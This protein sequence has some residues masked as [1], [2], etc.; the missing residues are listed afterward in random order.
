[1]LRVTVNSEADPIVIRVE[2]KLAG[3]SV[4]ELESCW[5]ATPTGR[6]LVVDVQSVTFASEDGRKLLARMY[7]AG[8]RLVASGMMM[9]AVVEQIKQSGPA[10]QKLS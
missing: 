9:S 3:P 1:M 4:A 10:P 8:A 2:G 7:R 5:A 6:G